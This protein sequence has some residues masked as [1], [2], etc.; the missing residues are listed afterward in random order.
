MHC[1]KLLKGGHVVIDEHESVNTH[2]EDNEGRIDDKTVGLHEGQHMIE[3][4]ITI[5]QNLSFVKQS[6]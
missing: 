1:I 4:R 6:V 3:E 2:F 5:L